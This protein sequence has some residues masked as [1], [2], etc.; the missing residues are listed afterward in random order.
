MPSAEHC[1]IV[2]GQNSGLGGG[3]MRENSE[4][5]KRADCVC[6]GLRGLGFCR[7]WVD[8]AGDTTLQFGRQW[9]ITTPRTQTFSGR[10]WLTCWG[11]ASGKGRRNPSVPKK[12]GRRPR[13]RKR[14]TQPLRTQK[15]PPKNR[16]EDEKIGRKNRT[17][18]SFVLVLR[19]DYIGI[20][21]RILSPWCQLPA[22]QCG[23]RFQ[24]CVPK[25]L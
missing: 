4:P 13:Q 19:R 7:Y 18:R 6:Y 20:F 24:P 14:K 11:R 3:F 8:G 23:D 12:T 17:E 21:E 9:L 15:I 22:L 10:S 5:S 2:G 1:G 16:T 25:K